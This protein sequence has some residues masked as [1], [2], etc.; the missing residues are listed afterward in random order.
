M[1]KHHFLAST[2][3][4]SFVVTTYQTHTMMPLFSYYYC[5]YYEHNIIKKEPRNHSLDGSLTTFVCLFFC[6]FVGLIKLSIHTRHCNNP[7]EVVY[8]AFAIVSGKWPEALAKMQLP[9]WQS[10]CY[11]HRNDR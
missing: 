7:L 4:F 2:F 6:Q 9:L 5:Y 11:R 1:K 10:C 8:L 3:P